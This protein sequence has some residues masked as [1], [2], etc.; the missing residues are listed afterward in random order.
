MAFTGNS[1]YTVAGYSAF[2][3]EKAVAKDW[4][5]I[6]TS[7]HPLLIAMADKGTNFNQ[8]F[9]LGNGTAM[10]IA[11]NG[12]NMTTPAAGV[13]DAS[14]LTG[15]TISATNGFSQANY[16]IAH[17]RAHV[18]YRASEQ[19]MA[20]NGSR[21]NILDGKKKQVLESFKEVWSTDAASST[22]DSRTKIMGYRYALSTSNSPGGISQSTDTQWAAKVKTS[23]GTF[24][25]NL[26]DDQVDNITA[27]GRG[28]PDLIL[29]GLS[30]AS[31]MFGKIRTAI[32][33]T[34][35][36]LVNPNGMPVKYGLTA[37]QYLGATV[38]LDN[39]AATGEINVLTTD[40][41]YVYMPK[42]PKVSQMYIKDGT[43][44]HVQSYT[45]F[46][47]LGCGDCAL[48]AT[49]TGIT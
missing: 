8:N 42:T 49:I 5:T 40:S 26:I 22:V 47:S 17:Y 27:E 24:G 31:N 11:V 29:A 30:G 13:A 44:S 41:W 25:L 15:D 3:V 46:T 19:F 43:D 10:L 20:E 4:H 32:G 2:A 1:N 12:D 9:D 14:E 21:G 34:A 38:I 37:I 7:A 35:E 36:R 6:W 48:N 16:Y 23:A 33:P 45:L 18:S 39:R 28:A